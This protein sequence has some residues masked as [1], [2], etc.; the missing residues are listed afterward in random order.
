MATKK[1]NDPSIVEVDIST[2]PAY[3]TVAFDADD[4]KLYYLEHQIV[5][6]A[7]ATLAI[8]MSGIY[9]FHGTTST[10]TITNGIVGP[11]HLF[12][13]GTGD[14]QINAT[15]NANILD[16]L[17]PGSSVTLYWDGTQYIL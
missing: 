16:S 11:V 15:L 17:V 10:W 14:I 4:G 8:N 12:N 2:L 6:S 1:F 3:R 5:R 9:S 7:A 13:G